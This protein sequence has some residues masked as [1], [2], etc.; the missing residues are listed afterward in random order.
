MKTKL[1][2]LALLAGG[3]LF[4]QTRFSIGVNIGGPAF[5]P[6]YYAPAPIRVM[7]PAYPGPGF[8]W[9]DGYWSRVRGRRIWAPGYWARRPGYVMAPRYSGFYPGYRYR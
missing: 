8:V 2:A 9:V 6:G 7:R 5:G 1:L 4:A 3:S